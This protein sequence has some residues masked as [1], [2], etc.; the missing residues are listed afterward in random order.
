MLEIIKKE[1]SDTITKIARIFDLGTQLLSRVKGMTSLVS[2]EN[3]NLT[4]EILKEIRQKLHPK[5]KRI[6]SAF[7]EIIQEGINRQEL[8][9]IDAKLGALTFLSMMRAAFLAQSHAPEIK[10][11][12]KKIVKMFFY[13]IK[14]REN[15]FNRKRS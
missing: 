7:A 12:N 8:K 5:I 15:D 6:V 3:I 9:K 14:L 1:E 10:D 11:P 4:A 2:L 13:G